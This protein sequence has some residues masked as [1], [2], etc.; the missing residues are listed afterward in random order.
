[1]ATESEVSIGGKYLGGTPKLVGDNQIVLFNASD[2]IA[3][4][5]IDDPEFFRAYQITIRELRRRLEALGYSLNHVRE[6]IVTELTKVYGELNGEM[7]VQC[8]KFLDYGCSIT[9]EQLIELVKNWKDQKPAAYNYMEQFN[10]DDF[11]TVLLDFIQGSS[12][13]LLLPSQNIWL[14][15]FYF[16]RLA[17]ETCTD[18]ELF[19]IDFTRLIEA[20]YY[21]PEAQ[22]ISDE[23]DRYLSQFNPLSFRLMEQ[24]NDEESET[25]EFKSVTSSNPC[26]AIE[27]QLPKYLIGF[28]NNKG[29]RI[30]FGVT[31][32]G[33]AEGIRLTRD[34]RD[35]LHRKVAAAILKIT[36]NFPQSSVEIK[37][38][39]LISLGKEMQDRFVVDIYIPSGK[40]NEMY[41]THGGETW[42]RHGTSTSQLS[43]HQLFAHICARYSTADDL[44][45]AVDLKARTAMDEIQRLKK[46][47]TSS[48]EELASKQG[49]LLELR[50]SVSTAW[51]HLK[52]IGLI[53]PTCEAPIAVRQSFSRTMSI[54]G[55]EIDADFEYIQYECGYATRDDLSEPDSPC[56]QNSNSP[57]SR[58]TL[59]DH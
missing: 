59:H 7:A 38:R 42:I 9:I 45:R 36:P 30:L 44:L 24:I 3:I 15:G 56:P 53:C 58:R 23:Y 25:L 33:V 29:G 20:G 47:G 35:L 18:D 22:P 32:S 49:E 6:A 37:L 14:N 46:L 12:S 27:K 54:G 4:G 28:L 21:A 10:L 57:S 40:S 16:E 43:G 51:Q 31:D 26:S 52:A 13:E 48:A 5:S 19:T 2:L 11:P 39:P 1:M 34:D 17:C 41:F 50:E 55:R 8:K